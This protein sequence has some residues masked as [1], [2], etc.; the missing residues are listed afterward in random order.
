VSEILKAKY[1]VS[2]HLRAKADLST[3]SLYV[4]ATE[5]QTDK[6]R[7]RERHTHRQTD[8]TATTASHLL[9]S[10]RQ[11]AN[12]LEMHRLSVLKY[13]YRY[14]RC[15]I[16]KKYLFAAWKQTQKQLDAGMQQYYTTLKNLLKTDLFKFPCPTICIATVNNP[17]VSC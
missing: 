6:G 1:T 15:F 7:Y 8:Y 11:A 16:C 14:P 3:P 4:V 2:L 9:L 10:D 5:Q 13:R 12:T 17:C